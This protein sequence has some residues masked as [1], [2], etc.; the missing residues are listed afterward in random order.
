MSLNDFQPFQINSK[1]FRSNQDL[2]ELKKY[3]LKYDCEGFDERN[4]FLHRKFFRFEMYS[5]LKFHY[6]RNSNKRS[7]SETAF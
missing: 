2:P 1:L 6:I 4:N 5:E 3:E 7:K